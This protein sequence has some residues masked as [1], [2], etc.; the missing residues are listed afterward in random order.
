MSALTAPAVAPATPFRPTPPAGRTGF[1]GDH[2][3][4]TRRAAA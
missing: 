1:G 3:V 4:P 2:A